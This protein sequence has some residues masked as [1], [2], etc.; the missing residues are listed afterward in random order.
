[1][2]ENVISLLEVAAGNFINMNVFGLFDISHFDITNVS[3][4]YWNGQYV[5]LH[6]NSCNDCI[7]L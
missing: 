1:M 3:L 5:I 6:Y 7:G 2:D 4:T